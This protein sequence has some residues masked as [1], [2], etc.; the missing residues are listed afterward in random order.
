[1]TATVA[2]KAVTTLM[3]MKA[4]PLGAGVINGR[5]MTIGVHT[6]RDRVFFFSF[7]GLWGHEIE[8]RRSTDPT[9]L[10]ARGRH[11]LFHR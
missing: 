11:V 10:R 8:E 3:A 5:S 2:R 4:T 6:R 7:F 1:M 9:H